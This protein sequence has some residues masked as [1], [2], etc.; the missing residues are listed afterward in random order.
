MLGKASLARDQTCEPIVMISY[1][2]GLVFRACCVKARENLDFVQ[3][4]GADL[5]DPGNSSPF[6]CR[7]AVCYSSL[8]TCM[9]VTYPS[10][11]CHISGFYQSQINNIRER[12][13]RD[14]SVGKV[15]GVQT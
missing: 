10:C 13:L 8:G 4:N 12:G 9:S 7:G 15:L 11:G 6:Q 3:G 1:Q 2:C 14:G 5:Q